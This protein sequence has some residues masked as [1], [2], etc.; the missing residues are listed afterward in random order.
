MKRGST[1]E[2]IKA[3]AH[4]ESR[5]GSSGLL[6]M[7][8]TIAWELLEMCEDMFNEGKIGKYIIKRVKLGGD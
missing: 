7:Q 5:E 4:D 8:G 6:E 1:G 3:Y 2:E